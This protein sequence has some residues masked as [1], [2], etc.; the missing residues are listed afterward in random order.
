MELDRKSLRWQGICA[1]VAQGILAN[2]V[3]TYKLDAQT[4]S[5]A[6]TLGEVDR[7]N[8]K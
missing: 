8:K 7:S 5:P 2:K 4:V 6:P 3:N 1:A